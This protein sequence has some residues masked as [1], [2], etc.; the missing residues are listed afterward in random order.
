MPLRELTQL[1][2]KGDPESVYIEGDFWHE[3]KR[4]F[5]HE[6]A[7]PAIGVDSWSGD[8][9]FP[10]QPCVQPAVG[11]GAAPTGCQATIINLPNLPNQ[12]EATKPRPEVRLVPKS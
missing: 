1:G 11:A 12:A 4:R 9:H 8:G 6:H 2:V 3:L 10:G 5:G 7:I